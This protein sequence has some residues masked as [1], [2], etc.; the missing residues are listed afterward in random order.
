MTLACVRRGSHAV[1]GVLAIAFVGWLGHVGVPAVQDILVLLF[2]GP[3]LYP[4]LS[5]GNLLT[6]VVV[7]TAISLL[8]P[9]YPSVLAARVPPVVA[10]R[11]KE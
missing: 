8:S 3:R 7:V 1:G 11:G 4:T 10:M 5:L 9:L 6:G 2:A